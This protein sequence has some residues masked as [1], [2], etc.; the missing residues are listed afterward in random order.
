MKWC[1]QAM[2]FMQGGGKALDTKMV[3]DNCIIIQGGV[4]TCHDTP[5][6]NLLFS[7]IV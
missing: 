3:P 1:A 2:K 6:W 7:K 5:Y 4:L